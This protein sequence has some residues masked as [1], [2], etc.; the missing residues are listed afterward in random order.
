MN[1]GDIL[2]PKSYQGTITALEKMG[3]ES[4]LVYCV[5]HRYIGGVIW[6]IKNVADS[7]ILL[8]NKYSNVPDTPLVLA[9]ESG[10]YDILEHL[11]RSGADIDYFGGHALTCACMDNDTH[12]IIKLLSLGATVSIDHLRAAVFGGQMTTL[13]LIL[14]SGIKP[15]KLFIQDIIKVNKEYDGAFD[16][17][18]NLLKTYLKWLS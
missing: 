12:C 3:A 8:D 10:Q 15:D 1:S 16:S 11:V 18:I 13:F 9:A 5:K 2:K 4:A 17:A 6:A 14:G 7:N